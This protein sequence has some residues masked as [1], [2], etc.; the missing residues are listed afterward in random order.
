MAQAIVER[1]KTE[2]A[3]GSDNGFAG[4]LTTLTG[5]SLE[6]IADVLGRKVAKRK[7]DMKMLGLQTHT[8]LSVVNMQLKVDAEKMRERRGDRLLPILEALAGAAGE[9]LENEAE[10]AEQE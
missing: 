8:A 3:A 6:V 5:R 7:P 1:A 2:I 10:P 9:T 4:Q